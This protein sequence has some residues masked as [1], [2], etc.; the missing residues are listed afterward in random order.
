VAK[1]ARLSAKAGIQK[2]R[3]RWCEWNIPDWIPAFAGMT[4]LGREMPYFATQDECAL[5]HPGFEQGRTH[6]LCIAL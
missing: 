6:G 2:L 1:I 4:A 3:K 5:A